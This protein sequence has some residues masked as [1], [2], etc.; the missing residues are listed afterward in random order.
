MPSRV[1]KIFEKL[2][3]VR[4]KQPGFTKSPEK[5]DNFI[6]R[7]LDVKIAEMTEDYNYYASSYAQSVLIFRELTKIPEFQELAETDILK[8]YE[9]AK[10]YDAKV[11]LSKKEIISIF[12]SELPSLRRNAFKYAKRYAS[13]VKNNAPHYSEDKL[14]NEY[15]RIAQAFELGNAPF[16][17]SIYFAKAFS[18]Y[19]E[20]YGLEAS[21]KFTK[22]NK[23]YLNAAVNYE[24]LGDV[25]NAAMCYDL[26]KI[27]SARRQAM[28]LYIEVA[29]KYIKE[30]NVIGA[31]KVLTR[32]AKINDLISVQLSNGLAHVDDPE[33]H[34]IDFVSLGAELR[35]ERKKIK[36]LLAQI[37]DK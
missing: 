21:A 1:R 35:E 7:H 13:V 29:E 12:S 25:F 6:R 34:R 3:L 32:A 28:Y 22:D 4:K 11:L 8:I 36:E 16:R 2:G 20:K 14:I 27:V 37:K 33:L 15:I 30:G 26:S 31:K 10:T 9:L 24:K 23:E 5:L 19:A 18:L 17:S